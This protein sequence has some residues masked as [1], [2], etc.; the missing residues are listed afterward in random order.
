MATYPVRNK[1]T[2]ETKEVVMSIYEWDS[3]LEE[4]GEQWERY[5]TPDNAPCLGVEVGEWSDRL[6]KKHP[7]FNEVLKKASKAPGAKIKPF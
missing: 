1:Q 3:W 2:G 7:S 5:Y 6:M 4:N